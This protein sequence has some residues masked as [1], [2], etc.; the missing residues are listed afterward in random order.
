MRPTSY[1]QALFTL[2]HEEK[3]TE[4]EL[5]KHFLGTVERNGHRHLLPHILREY[6]KL[7]HRESRKRIVTLISEKVLSEDDCA[8]LLKDPEIVA[9]VREKNPQIL[10]KKDGSLVGGTIIEIGS[11]RIDRS[12]KR[13]LVELY[14]SLTTS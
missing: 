13:M 11:K 5:V 7:E 10:Q 8:R 2:A 3:M 9:L 14:H 4:E 6:A 1:A 12:Y